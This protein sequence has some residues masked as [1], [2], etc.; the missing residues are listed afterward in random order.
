MGFARDYVIFSIAQNISMGTEETK[1]KKNYYVNLGQQQGVD[2]GTA[3]EVYR[4]ISL[5]DPFETKKRHNYRVKIGE[6]EVLHSEQESSIAIVKD[7]Q[8]GAKVPMFEIGNFM[9]GDKIDVET[10]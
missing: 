8:N 7:I 2:S 3:L 4:I 9:V 5:N 10:N 1:P 6:L